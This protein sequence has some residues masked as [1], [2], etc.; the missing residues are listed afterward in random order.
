MTDNRRLWKNHALEHIFTAIWSGPCLAV[1]PHGGHHS[2]YPHSIDGAVMRD[3]FCFWWQCTRFA[4]TGTVAVARS[5]WWLLAVPIIG[6]LRYLSV[7]NGMESITPDHPILDSTLFIIAA[8]FLVWTF[9]F[10]IRFGRVPPQLYYQEQRRADDLQER[11]KPKLHLVFEPNAGCVVDTSNEGI[12]ARYFRVL[13][14]CDSE[15]DIEC[16][17]QLRGVHYRVDENAQWSEP[18]LDETLELQWSSQSQPSSWWR[19]RKGSRQFVDVCMVSG[20]FTGGPLVP[21]GVNLPNRFYRAFDQPGYYRFD[22]A[23]ISGAADH[24]ISIQVKNA[25]RYN[26]WKNATARILE[27]DELAVAVAA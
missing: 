13:P 9:A 4:A 21:C 14:I 11:F 16:R 1:L 7:R 10:V 25:G 22:V 18:L 8:F 23:V 15:G 3:F 24:F 2:L 20:G 27:E 17:A 12:P 5:F 19:I 26:D 6:A